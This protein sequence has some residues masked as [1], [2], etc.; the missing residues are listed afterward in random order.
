MNRQC[1]KLSGECNLLFPRNVLIS[2]YEDAVFQQRVS[3]GFYCRF[4]QRPSCINP[5]N[6]RAN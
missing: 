1:A 6:F 4:V 2:K 5:V 3:D